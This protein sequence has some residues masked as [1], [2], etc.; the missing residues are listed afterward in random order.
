MLL[1]CLFDAADM[2]GNHHVHRQDPNQHASLQ[3]VWLDMQRRGPVLQQRGLF[4]QPDEQGMRPHAAHVRAVLDHHRLHN[5]WYILQTAGKRNRLR[6][7]VC[8]LRHYLTH[9]YA[10]WALQ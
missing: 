10:M 8:G 9:L 5:P 4:V 6:E 2:L 7:Q 3:L 1:Q